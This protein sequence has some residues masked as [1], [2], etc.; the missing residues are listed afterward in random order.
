MV[1]VTNKQ[2]L[3]DLIARSRQEPIVIFKH[4]TTCPISADAYKEMA[5]FSGDVALIEVQNAREVSRE[6]EARTGVD[7]ES[8]QVIILRNGRAVWHAS[9]WKIRSDTVS[10]ALAGNQ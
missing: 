10:D 1:K 3:E 9:H 5:R 8:P 7:H 2:E 6:L 4:S